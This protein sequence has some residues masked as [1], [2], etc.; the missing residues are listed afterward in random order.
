M[1]WGGG[2]PALGGVDGW[3]GGTGLSLPPCLLQP[4][5][6]TPWF[7]HIQVLAAWGPFLPHQGPRAQ[8]LGSHPALPSPQPTQP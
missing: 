2:C 8:T 5:E 6:K 3:L 7:C 1:G 4:S